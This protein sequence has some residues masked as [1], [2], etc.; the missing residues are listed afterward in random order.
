MAKKSKKTKKAAKPK[1]HVRARKAAS[2]K[3]VSRR[4]TS[5]KV[6]SQTSLHC[7]S[8]PV[9]K[10]V[11]QAPVTPLTEDQIQKFREVLTQKR[12]DLMAIVQRKKEEEIEDVGVGDEADIATR[13]VEKEML[14][15]LTDSEKQ[16]LDRIEAALRKMEKGV[17]G[18]CESC[19]RGIPRLRLQVMPWARYC[20]NCQA[21]QEVPVAE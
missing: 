8:K 1:K 5:R 9:A 7:A 17:Y 4:A 3:V 6:I 10:K 19:Q 12:D 2:R 14:F 18:A 11:P 21:E 15:E 16:T 13:S 20:I